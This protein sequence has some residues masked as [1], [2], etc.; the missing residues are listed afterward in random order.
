MGSMG[1]TIATSIIG[2]GNK[3]HWTSEGRSEQTVSNA[4]KFNQAIEHQTIEEL[5]CNS[6]VVFCIGKLGASFD[7]VTAAVKYGFKGIYVDG[8]NLHGEDSERQIREIAGDSEF[9]YIEALLRGYALGYDQGGG[10]D[11]RD[12]YL[13]GD[14]ESAKAVES[15]FKDG[16]WKV[17]L[18]AESAKA[19][20]RTRF[21]RLF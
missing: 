19:L 17:H 21:K 11:K 9:T 4:R 3:V 13:S 5:F 7:T 14:L 12:M 8:N 6:D 15:L 1:L 2:S 16:V 20:N 18:V 10:E